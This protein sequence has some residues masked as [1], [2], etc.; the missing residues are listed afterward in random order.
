MTD[1]VQQQ[2]PT[3]AGDDHATAGGTRRQRRQRLPR[4]AGSRPW[5]PWVV[6][7]LAAIVALVSTVQWLRLAD[8]EATRDEVET[9]AATFVIEL[10]NWDAT[11]GLAD[12]R[13]ALQAAGTPAFRNEVDELFG[14]E[15]GTELETVGA[16]SRGEVQDVFLQR[17][18]EAPGSGEEA[19]PDD[20]PLPTAVVFA[21]VEQTVASELSDV[22][23]VIRRSARIVLH[24]IDGAWKVADVELIQDDSSLVPAP[25]ETP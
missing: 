24:R 2:D 14:G 20:E 5:L 23:D 17:I 19:G 12:T 9:A 18:E 21:V 11:D 4:A 13:E 8:R 22:P 16:V 10:T 25:E 7:V 3:E 15:L 1:A 6:A